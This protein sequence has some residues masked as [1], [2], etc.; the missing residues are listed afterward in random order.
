MYQTARTKWQLRWVNISFVLLFLAAVGLLQWLSGQH[1]LQFDL[2]QNAR[3]SLSPA[4]RAVLEP[5]KGPLDVTVFA[6]KRGELRQMIRGQL[7]RYRR[8]KSDMRIEFVDP[9]T[10]PERLRVEGIRFDGSVLLKYGDVKEILPPTS[11]NEEGITNA[12]TRLGHREKRWV[13]FLAGHG[14]RDPD[15]RANFDLSAWTTELRNRGFKTR[16][17]A[18]AEHP[19]IPRNTSVLVIAGP[20][21]QLLA[22]EVKEIA[23]YVK[24]GGNLLWLSDPGALHGL[25]PIA[26]MLGI[27]FQ[28]GVIV[29][30]SSEVITGN[31]TAIVVAKYTGHSVVRNFRDITLFPHAVGITL[32]APKGWKGSVL[33]DTRRTAWSETGGLGGKGPI[34]FDRGRDIPGPLNLGVAL[35]RILEG[36]TNRSKREQR[37]IV[38]G[39]G[40]FL[41]NTY[42]ANGGNLEFGMSLANWLSQDDAYVSIPVRTL[43][44][45]SLN[46]SATARL[47]L[48][49]TFMIL[50]PL[51]LGTSGLVIWLRR[52]KL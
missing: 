19:Q 38:I 7:E 52:R 29:D 46:L 37:I 31:A 24:K 5:L 12:F 2:T 40:D 32:H 18:L 41:S 8:Y 50:L 3:H 1:Y 48:V 4:S 45:R 23:D 35:T 26:E 11:L 13:V 51:L 6:S 47:A 20:Q 30:P 15:R 42:I 21:L 34:E 33:F 39:D 22:G 36:T 16:K 9:D 14:E 43:R 10:A 17:L 49:G 44:D 28:P 25:E 27:E